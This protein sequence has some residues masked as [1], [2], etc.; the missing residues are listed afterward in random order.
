MYLAPNY[1]GVDL[2]SAI[3]YILDR[4]DMKLVE[5]NDVFK[6]IPED[7]DSLRTNITIDDS[8]EFLI[9]DFDKVS[10]LFDFFNEIN[11]YGNAH[12]AVRK[13][14]R[15]IQKRG[16]KTLEVVDNTL[17][18]QEEVDKRATKLL[19]IHSRLNQKLSFTL[20]SRGIA[21]V[22]VGDIVN[23]SI[24]RENIEMNEY[25]VL[26]MEHQLTGF[27][28]LQL[29][30][31]SKDLS[32]VFSELLISSK[33]T[34]AA[35]RSNDLSTQEVSFN[36]LDTVDTKEIKLLVR[37]RSAGG[38]G[39]TLGFGTALGFTTPLGFTGGAITITDLVEEDLA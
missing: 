1:Q 12:K 5:E 30:R 2:Y 34:K 37:K 21:Q 15:S 7:E 24:P 22:R 32:D 13:D 36:F 20:H 39:R 11:V 4:K 35:L 26:E 38:A 25:I 6:I 17:L 33:E 18:T 31:Y 16:R 3:R 10:T 28:K 14:I 19:R 27:I 23:V 8:D 29:G 9:I